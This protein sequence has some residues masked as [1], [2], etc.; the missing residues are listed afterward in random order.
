MSALGI[1]PTIHGLHE[2][3]RPTWPGEEHLDRA[4]LRRRRVARVGRDHN[5]ADPGKIE[6]F[7]ATEQSNSHWIGLRKLELFEEQFLR[8]RITDLA[9]E[10]DRLEPIAILRGCI[11][12][13]TAQG[14][15]RRCVLHPRQ[16][17]EQE[18]V[19]RFL[20]QQCG[21]G[22]GVAGGGTASSG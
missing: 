5:F 2:S 10:I 1:L 17:F 13:D 14:G 22:A 4:S 21:R 8:A 16:H 6:C 11:R 12:D 18:Q 15:P 7:E 19:F 3:Q 9:Q 20:L